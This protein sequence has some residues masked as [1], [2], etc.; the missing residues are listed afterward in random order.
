MR[1]K[2][3]SWISIVQYLNIIINCSESFK[4]VKEIL[5]FQKKMHKNQLILIPPT[6]ISPGPKSSKKSDPK[7]E[8]T[9]Y[10][11]SLSWRNTYTF[12]IE[13]SFYGTRSL[14]LVTHFVVSTDI[15]YTFL[16]INHILYCPYHF[17]CTMH[18]MI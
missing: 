5:P 6:G 10:K 2:I 1:I 7:R 14:N 15:I 4:N 18:R 17:F 3:K 11:R 9:Y 16:F 8:K 13:N 12:N